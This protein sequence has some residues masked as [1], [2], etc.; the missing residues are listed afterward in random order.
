MGLHRHDWSDVDGDGLS[1]LFVGALRYQ[2]T[3]PREGAAFIYRGARDR[4]LRPIW[5]RVGGKAGSWYGGAGGPAGDL[6]G[7][8]AP[9]FVV[10]A[11]AWDSE[12]GINVGRVD[13]FLNRRQN[14]RQR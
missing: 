7:D 4:S 3:E 12:T 2:S 14:R 13:V 1:D 5:T 11:H 9:D 8:G 10:S 6:N